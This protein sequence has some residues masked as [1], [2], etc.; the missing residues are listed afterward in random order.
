MTGVRAIVYDGKE[1][2][3]D[4]KEIAFQTA[5]REAFREAMM[6]A[7][8]T[9]LEPVYDVTVTVPEENMGD[10]LGD[11]NGRRARVQGMDTTGNRS[12]IKAE[13]PLS[14]MQSYSADLR[15]MTGGR[16]IYGMTFAHYGQVP[17]HL[18]SKIVSS[19]TA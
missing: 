10:I 4:S 16:G 3:V 19:G 12:I 15:S 13:V 6:S 9:L 11:M 1:H 8:P 7:N 5:G 18:Q 17:N 2:P 14:E